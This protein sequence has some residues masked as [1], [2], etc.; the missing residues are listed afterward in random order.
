MTSH[1]VLSTDPV[2]NPVCNS[3]NPVKSG[4]VW[5]RSGSGQNSW[6]GRTLEI[7]STPYVYYGYARHTH[8]ATGHG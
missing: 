8:T 2:E 7:E 6:S 3:A 4:P 1:I 5:F